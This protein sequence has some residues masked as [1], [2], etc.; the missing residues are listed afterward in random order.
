MRKRQMKKN[1]KRRAGAEPEPRGTSRE[2]RVMEQMAVSGEGS[3]QGRRTERPAVEPTQPETRS[4]GEEE[5]SQPHDESRHGRT[6]EGYDEVEEAGRESFPAS[7]PP[8]WTP[9]R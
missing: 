4:E 5:R 9:E 6:R 7:D 2:R 3:G 1:R 8:S